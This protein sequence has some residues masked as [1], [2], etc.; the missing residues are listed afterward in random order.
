MHLVEPKR[1]NKWV[2]DGAT[3]LAIQFWSLKNLNFDTPIIFPYIC[4]P[5]VQIGVF[6][7]PKM[8]INLALLKEKNIPIVRRDTG[9]GAIYLDQNGLN[10]SFL[11]PYEKNEKLL[12]NYQLF[13]DPIVA[14]LQKL[15]VKNLQF[16]GKNDL[17]IENKKI[18]G[19]A[20]ALINDRIYAGF[21]LLYDVDFDFIGEILKPNELKIISKGVSSVAQRVTNLKPKLPPKIQNL[22]LFE[23][24]DLILKEYLN[25]FQLKNFEIY[26][27]SDKDWK[28]IDELVA[29]KYKNW[30]FIWGQ[31]PDFSFN[32]TIRL[33][34]GTFTFSFEIVEGIIKKA[35]IYGDFFA[36]KPIS[37][38]ESHL[39]GTKLE[40][41]SLK[42]CFETANLQDFFSKKIDIN[43]ICDLILT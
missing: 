27:L 30:D 42:V 1:G 6:Q 15:G 29:K 38:L 26:Q 32:K 8:E 31:T 43:Q 4:D 21:S 20:M 23:L 11:F 28:E 35:K 34:I 17:Q 9:G 37:T 41:Q 5:H 14:I 39:I 36:K 40:K 10:F 16:S 18:S 22:S 24:K 13:Y 25:F 7:N 12:G 33:P 2:F 3:L 19:A